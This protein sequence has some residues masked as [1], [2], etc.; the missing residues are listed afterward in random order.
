[1]D[2]TRSIVPGLGHRVRSLRQLGGISQRSL[3]R[4]AGLHQGH[5]WKIERGAENPELGTVLGL[6]RALG[7]SVGY[8]ANAEGAPPSGEEVC[9]ALAGCGVELH[10]SDSTDA[11]ADGEVAR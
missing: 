3:D 5:V 2:T 9:A 4:A 8:L 1:M 10:E 6:A 11:A 7:A